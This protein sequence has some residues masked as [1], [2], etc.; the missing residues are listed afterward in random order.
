[1]VKSGTGGDAMR[2][3]GEFGFILVI[4]VDMVARHRAI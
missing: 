3:K 1:M 4:P 2:N